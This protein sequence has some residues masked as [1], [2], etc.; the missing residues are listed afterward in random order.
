MMIH[1]INGY[2]LETLFFG[3]WGAIFFDLNNNSIDKQHFWGDEDFL[4]TLRTQQLSDE[5]NYF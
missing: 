5:M 2:I 3:G 4:L 1:Y